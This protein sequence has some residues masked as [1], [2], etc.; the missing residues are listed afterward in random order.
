MAASLLA[1]LLA[2]NASGG[3]IVA[4][5]HGAYTGA[6]ENFGDTEDAVTPA[7][8]HRFEELVGKRQAIIASS[9]FWGKGSFPTENV[10]AIREAG[11]VP[12]LYW[13]PW[14]PPYEQGKNVD[15]GDYSLKHI[16]HGDCDAY[17]DR[18]AAGARDSGGPLLVSFA[19]EPNSNWFPWS[20]RANGAGD[21]GPALYREAYRHVVDRAR[22]AGARNVQWVFHANNDSHPDKKWNAI[23]QYYPGAAYVDW[24]GMSAYG[25]LTPSDDD[26]PSWAD[27]MDDAYQALCALDPVKPVM[28][29]EWGV[30]EFPKSGDKAKWIR[31]AFA[32][33]NAGR[34]PRLKAAIFWHERWQNGDE[35]YSD[36]RVDSSPTALK[37]YREGVAA[38]QWLDSVKLVP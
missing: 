29:A 8:I 6:Y 17:I 2:A 26:W 27:T 10:R 16:I 1:L 25:Q 18:W 31:T 19:C 11:A 30:G 32:E 5:E 37:A 38:P 14:G 23:A 33:M 7:A 15:P 4:P 35:T 28:L 22:A 21:A 34:Y 9:S 24:L 36:L 20:G 13:S 12:L 3:G